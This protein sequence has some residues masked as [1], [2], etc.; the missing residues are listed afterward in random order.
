MFNNLS[1]RKL[2]IAYSVIA[3]VWVAVV[4]M[5]GYRSTS[6][7]S[8]SLEDV[9]NVQTAMRL[10]LDADMM[11]DAIRGDAL[12]ALLAARDGQV[13]KEAEILKEFN[14][15]LTRM[16]ESMSQN[17]AMSLG[18]DVRQQIEKVMPVINSYADR[19]QL[20][21]KDAFHN[22]TA[23]AQSM[24]A[25]EKEFDTLEI[26]MGKL[27]E[28]I[29]ALNDR[30][31]AHADS[32]SN[33]A[34]MIIGIISLTSFFV[35]TFIAFYVVRKVTLPLNDL[36]NVVIKIEQTG[37]LTLRAIAHGENEISQ[38][39]NA[40][41]RLIN[42]MQL[43]VKEVHLNVGQ[44]SSAT[45]DLVTAESALEAT[46]IQLGESVATIAANMEEVSTSIDQVAEIA[47]TAE[48]VSEGA[49]T[50]SSRGQVIVNDTLAEITH[51]S[52][53]VSEA[54][55]Q[56]AVLSQRSDDISGIVK[57]IKEIADQT[58]LLA[59]NAAIEAA[60]AG[61]QGRGFAVVADE[62]RKL[63]ERTGRATVEIS[64]LIASIQQE[65]GNAVRKMDSSKNH[66][67]RGLQLASEAGKALE[68]ISSG[69]SNSAKHAKETAHATKEQ[70]A[71][72]QEV[73]TAVEKIAQLSDKNN[74]S[75]VAAA[76]VAKN[77]ET[78]AQ[79]LKTAANRFKS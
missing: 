38:T 3:V 15:H 4:G 45:S 55:Q 67:D 52:Q 62:V 33:R 30:T 35:L 16:K 39:V 9:A 28:L 22:P 56:I 6:L 10:Q 69:T 63:A 74:Q 13:E 79:N 58:N 66:A 21:M 8:A 12:G 60:R 36:A 41:N 47:R 44:V 11:H 72:V 78:L 59:L 71:A 14:G 42:S 49:R 53:S 1:I 70:S 77:L 40:F 68:S 73:A 27:S 37:D 46:S 17:V 57:V 23:V 43:I 31:K 18:D 32:V 20:I 50:E 34:A 26:E 54:S 51:I 61:E 7:I 19:G 76:Q 25:F 5:V 75:M 2:L 64:G 24:P 65:T 29:G 48:T